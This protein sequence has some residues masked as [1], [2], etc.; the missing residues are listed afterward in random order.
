MSTLTDLKSKD[1][2][3]ALASSAPAPGGGGGA[4][5]A[6]ALAA[7]LASMVCNLTIGK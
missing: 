6:G 3:T 2:L 5:M 1:F 7:A 4:A